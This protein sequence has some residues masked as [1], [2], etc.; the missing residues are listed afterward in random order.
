MEL[1]F[2]APVA[3]AWATAENIAAL[4]ARAEDLGYHSLWTFQRLLSPVR[5]DGS[6]KLDPPYRSVQ[7][8][9]AVTAFLAGHTRRV[10]LGLGVVNAP[11]FS[12]VLLAKQLTTIDHLSA[13][14]L[15]TGLGLGWLEDEFQATNVP[16][17]HRG[18]RTED[19]VRCLRAIWTDDVVDYEGPY[20]RVPRSRVDPK[21]LQHPHPPILF[22]ATAVPSLRRAGRL[23][24]GWISASRAD[25][26]TLAESVSVVRAA[27]ET[28]GRDPS[29]LRFVCR[30]V[31]KVRDGERAP[32]TGSLDEIAGD[33]RLLAEAGI[34]EAFVDLNFDPSIGS[35]D[36]DPTASLRHAHRVLE[37]LAPS[38]P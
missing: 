24:T 1:G 29:L 20:Y 14:R 22:G 17:A 6:Q 9:L 13:G 3:G 31:V 12:P 28:A 5:A 11:F 4:A 30:A 2:A 36:A 15:D 10:R 32:F 23:G 19:F 35:P 38:D 33:L 21:P 16:S 8:P 7:D 37:A 18:P 25:P 27:A 26:S 34:T